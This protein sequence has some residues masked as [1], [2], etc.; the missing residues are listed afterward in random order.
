MV[1]RVCIHKQLLLIQGIDI[2]EILDLRSRSSHL[3]RSKCYQGSP[4]GGPRSD[5]EPRRA[6]IKTGKQ[7][8][9]R[10]AIMMPTQQS[11][12]R[13]PITCHDPS[14]PGFD[15]LLS[16]KWGRGA[17]PL[18]DSSSD[19]SP[20]TDA[21]RIWQDEMHSPGRTTPGGERQDGFVTPTAGQHFKHAG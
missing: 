16:N 10:A 6:G 20:P 19:S 2:L 3:L 21:L 15:Y 1:K 14:Q 4:R 8:G 13:W 11:S 9:N 5:F 17:P 7:L 18:S 12:S